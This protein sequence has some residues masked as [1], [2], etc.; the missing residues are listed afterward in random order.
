[1]GVRGLA[2]AAASNRELQTMDIAN[3]FIWEKLQK[4]QAPWQIIPSLCSEIAYRVCVEARCCGSHGLE[5]NVFVDVSNEEIEPIESDFHEVEI[6][7]KAT[8]QEGDVIGQT[9]D[10]EFL[11]V[12]EASSP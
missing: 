3:C 6:E 8:E 9:Y 4:A 10:P 5:L 11:R 1:M 7:N 2:N 12:L